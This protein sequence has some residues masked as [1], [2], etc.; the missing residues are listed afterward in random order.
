MVKRET[1]GV[2]SQTSTVNHQMP[3]GKIDKKD[4]FSGPKSVFFTFHVSRL[5]TFVR[6]MPGVTSLI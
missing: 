2:K 4:A 5:P 3:D 6:V 1:A